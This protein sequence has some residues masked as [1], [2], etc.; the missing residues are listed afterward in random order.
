MNKYLV[1]FSFMLLASCRVGP[2]YKRPEFFSD[3]DLGTSLNLNAISSQ[4]I[5]A[6][7]YRQFNDETLNGL[8]ANAL[9]TSP[10]VSIAIQ[11]LRQARESL[12]IKSVQYFPTLDADG[13]YHYAKTSKNIGL[14]ISTDYYQTGLDASWELDIWGAGARQT[15]EYEALYRAAGANLDNVRLSLVSEV[16]NNYINL[17]TAQK[18]LEIAN[19]NLKLQNDIYEIVK[20]KYDVG[21][22]D[23]IALNQAKYVLETTRT[24]IPALEYNIEAYKNALAI[25]S[26]LLPG[27][28]DSRLDVTGENIAGRQFDFDLNKL[29]ELPL[30]SIR[31]RPDV[32][33]AENNLIAKNAAV[34]Q[35]VAALYPNVSLGGFWGYQA[36]NAGN[37][38]APD[39]NM[40]T[41]TPGLTLPVFH[42]GELTNNV[43][44]QKDIKTE[45]VYLYKNSVLNAAG[46]I[47]NAMVSVTKEYDKNRAYRNSVGSMQEVT[48]LMVVKYKE[49]LV[50]FSDLLTSE[51]N[52]LQA[53]TDMIGSNGA[54]YQNIIAFYKASGGGYTYP[55][56]EPKPCYKKECMADF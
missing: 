40:Y 30:D 28:L 10:D 2:D 49:G 25:V 15:E 53:Q 12:K 44:L 22:A 5:A 55:S 23:D 4:Q 35:A 46:E 21:L 34:G 48:G 17:R 8:I 52:L 38:F 14:A 24:L 50:E 36:K 42:W 41:F 39:S 6:D 1:L 19:H 56:R 7:W 3:A 43:K 29:Y 54:I 32:Q 26:G 20:E 9:E 27:Q 37:L 47:K 45:Y 13:S 16:A 31:N 51:Q 33:I 18:Q 11:K